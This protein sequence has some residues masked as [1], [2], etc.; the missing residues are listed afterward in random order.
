MT[1]PKYTPPEHIKFI[2][3]TL[4]AYSKEAGFPPRS[5][6][7]LSPLEEWLLMRLYSEKLKK[8]K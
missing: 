5:T 2:C 3:D 8:D 4:R 1:E 6:S 7:D